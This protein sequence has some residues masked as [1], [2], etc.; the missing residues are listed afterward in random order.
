MGPT[1]REILVQTC[2]LANR[3]TRELVRFGSWYSTTLTARLIV[4]GEVE[5]SRNHRSWL[6]CYPRGACGRI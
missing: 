3:F 5:S 4:I 1:Q 2:P 6:V